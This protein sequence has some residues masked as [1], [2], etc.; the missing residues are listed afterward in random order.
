MH[1]MPILETII[2]R[3][4]PMQRTMSLHVS[5]TSLC[6][7]SLSKIQPCSMLQTKT[8]RQ[9]WLCIWTR[10]WASEMNS[11]RKFRHL[12]DAQMSFLDR[13]LTSEGEVKRKAITLIYEPRSFSKTPFHKTTNH[14][15][16]HQ[17][18]SEPLFHWNIATRCKA[19]SWVSCRGKWTKQQW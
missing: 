19:Q 2:A 11:L 1:S 10:I 12:Q 17:L 6:T 7:Q 3:S 16:Y 13:L 9:T 5:P 18:V 8:K 15:R 14:S 4:K